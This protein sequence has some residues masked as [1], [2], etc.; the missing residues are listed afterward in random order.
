MTNKHQHH[1]Q[2]HGSPEFL[3]AP[4]R[5]ALL[6]VPRV[7]ELC[8]QDVEVRRVLDVGTGSGVFVQA[9]ADAGCTVAGL[10]LSPKMLAYA[11]QQN[12]DIPFFLARMEELPFRDD[13]FDLIFLGHV[14]HETD[15]LAHTLGELHRCAR[16][17][18][19]ALEWP[20]LDEPAGPPLHHRLQPHTVAKIAGQT[21][22]A[23][24]ETIPL[25]RMVLYRFTQTD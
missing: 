13:A 4:A 21:G 20:Y 10:D 23:R 18:V 1:K 25:Q 14:L 3:A 2:F 6:E 9:F 16:T 19:A 24:V 22:F 7:V 5:L 12:P 17:R 8:L 15:D 11:R